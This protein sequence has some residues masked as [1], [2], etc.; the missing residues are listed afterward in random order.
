VRSFQ[1]KKCLPDH[2]SLQNPPVKPWPKKNRATD[3]LNSQSKSC[4]SSLLAAAEVPDPVSAMAARG[5]R[6]DLAGDA[7][8]KRI[9]PTLLIVGGRDTQVMERSHRAFELIP[10]QKKLEIVRNATHLYRRTRSSGA[11]PGIGQG[12][13]SPAPGA[14]ECAA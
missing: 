7:L 8:H 1:E 10:A 4:H 5:G 9:A 6:P 12:L 3:Q 11:C 2:T 13:V 14:S